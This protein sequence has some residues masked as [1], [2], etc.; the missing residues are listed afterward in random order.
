MVLSTF[1][2]IKSNQP[3]APL[4]PLRLLKTIGLLL[5]LLLVLAPTAVR[6]K[7]DS[8][9]GAQLLSSAKSVKA[10]QKVWMALRLKMSDH[11]HVYWRNP[12][13]AGYPPTLTWEDKSKAELL[14]PVP[15]KSNLSEIWAYV[16]EDEVLLPFEFQVPAQAAQGPLKLKGKAKW[17]ACKESCIPGDAEVDVQVD[18]ADAFEA[19][20]ENITIEKARQL[21][22]L[23]T[24]L[25]V[26]LGTVTKER[27]NLEFKG[28]TDV[29]GAEFFPQDN[30]QIEDGAPQKYQAQGDLSQLE[31][32]PA[33]DADLAKLSKLSGILTVQTGAGKQSY[34]VDATSQWNSGPEPSP[35]GQNSN[36][37]GQTNQAQGSAPP[38][39]FLS[40]LIGAVIGGLI[41][42]LMPCVFP[43]L[44][45]KIMGLV[46]HRDPEHKPILHGM[47]FA[48]GVLLSFWAVAGSLLL[49]RASGSQ[50]GWGFQLQSPKFVALMAALFFLIA[51]NL[52]GL[53]EVGEGLTQ[54]GEYSEGKTGY[55]ESFW[56]GALATLVATPCSAPYMGAA[57]GYA[58]TQPAWKGMM[59]FTALGVGMAAP[60]VLLTAFPALLRFLPRPG[61]WMETFKQ[62][63]AFPMLLAVVWFLW[64]LGSLAGPDGMAQSLA[65][66][67][68]LG[69]SAWTMNRWGYSVDE[70]VQKRAKAT[71]VLLVLLSVGGLMW[72]LEPLKR[73][74]VSNTAQS[75]E[76]IAWQPYSER[77]IEKARQEGKTVFVD[78]TADWCLSCKANE[79]VALK[80]ASVIAKF[81]KSQVAAFKAD[82]TTGDPV[83]TAALS[84]FGRSGVPLYVVYKGTGPAKVL[85][86]VISPS[87]VLSEIP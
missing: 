66:L 87:L 80:D 52:F 34:Q 35:S 83:I 51:L 18:V 44:S 17:L 32:K 57:V 1:L 53:F 21:L 9:V 39:D 69:M 74:S 25:T 78:F 15:Q 73:T 27:L 47:A 60:Y 8:H 29:K 70:S 75:G 84:K 6:A 19:G 42:N 58:L 24:G 71:A 12:G 41:L 64:I 31:L 61:A 38:V 28:A 26:R 11:W 45:L 65:C 59:I 85:P 56:S 48:M 13:S 20:P 67:I 22:P 23:S 77:E 79:K 14:W 37:T 33:A 62:F 7:P 63:M 49:L 76:G 4:A 82:W 3:A 5:S 16:Y 54:L 68:G 10:G 55:S 36:G 46:Q 2:N 40:S 30:G 86:E 81:Q 43:V 50:F 72:M